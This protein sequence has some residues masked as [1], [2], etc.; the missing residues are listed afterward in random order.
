[1]ARLAQLGLLGS[2]VVAVLMAR[3]SNLSTAQEAKTKAPAAAKTEATPAPSGE[4]ARPRG[5]LPSYY[6][7]VIT[8][9]QRESVYKVQQAYAPQIEKLE[10]ELETLRAERRKEI[11]ALLS[12]E[13]R[14]KVAELAQIARARRARIQAQIEAAE[15][16]QA[17]PDAKAGN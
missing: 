7:A 8:P 2:I 3:E 15:A 1:M 17:E 12:E 10:A 14:A 13:Q 5:R 4:R 9:D 16:A 6:N 11:E